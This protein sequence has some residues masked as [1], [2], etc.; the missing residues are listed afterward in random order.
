MNVIVL[1]GIGV[2]ALSAFLART[3]I[4]AEYAWW[5]PR[6]ATRIIHLASVIAPRPGQREEWLGLL[7]EQG[8][9]GVLFALQLV[10]ASVRMRVA[11]VNRKQR[12]YG[13]FKRSN[14]YLFS[15]YLAF[16]VVVDPIGLIEAIAR[17]NFGQAAYAVGYF[18]VTVAMFGFGVRMDLRAID[19]QWVETCAAS[20]ATR[21]QLDA[22]LWT[23]GEHAAMDVYTATVADY[24]NGT[25]W[26]R[27]RRR[28]ATYKTSRWLGGKLY[29]WKAGRVERR[30]AR[31]EPIA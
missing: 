5:G 28:L 27:A 13:W 25:S 24:N 20:C 12:A 7:A 3:V 4:R 16:F 29:D 19:V 31:H 2:I 30:A 6:V 11:H 17:H 14:L 1:V 9:P 10:P 15:I 22:C 21:D 23:R 8:V 26:L 18:A